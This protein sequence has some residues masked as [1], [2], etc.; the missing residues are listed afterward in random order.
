MKDNSEAPKKQK[1]EDLNVPLSDS[2]IPTDLSK[3]PKVKVSSANSENTGQ[4][5][6]SNSE[7]QSK[8][9]KKQEPV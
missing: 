5:M 3:S 4:E 1:K 9:Q 6:A 8:E 2:H 7:N